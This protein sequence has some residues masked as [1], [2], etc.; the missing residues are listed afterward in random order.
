MQIPAVSRDT[1]P[2]LLVFVAETTEYPLIK[3]RTGGIGERDQLAQ[4]IL[5]LGKRNLRLGVDNGQ[6]VAAM[7]APQKQA[8][9]LDGYDS[10]FLVEY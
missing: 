6:H 4:R 5:F 10:I 7:N 9:T 1:S 3:R 8:V 2:T